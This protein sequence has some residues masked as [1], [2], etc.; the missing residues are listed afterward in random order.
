MSSDNELFREIM[1]ELKDYIFQYH[2]L[3]SI[4]DISELTGIS[5]SKCNELCNILEGQK[6]IYVVS[7]GGHGRPKIIIPYEMMESI[8][9]TQPRPQWINQSQYTF[10]EIEELLKKLEN[11]NKDLD[12]FNKFQFLLHGTDIALEKAVTYTLN[13]LEFEN[14]VHHIKNRN[15]ADVTFNQ[16]DIKYLVEVE[17]TTKRANKDKILQLDGW[18]KI[19]IENNMPADKLKGIF[20]VNHERDEPP[21]ERGEPL[22]NHAK[23]FLKRY[24]F[25]FITT[26]FL[27]DIIKKVHYNKLSKTMARELIIKGEDF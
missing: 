23:E 3:P 10:S 25:I 7:G 11:I 6:Q 27:F 4:T 2:K 16:G 13:Y 1:K 15:Y 20:V 24:N 26:V 5:S 22:T 12:K 9:N 8:L 19:E 18:L 17:G 14:V 21:H